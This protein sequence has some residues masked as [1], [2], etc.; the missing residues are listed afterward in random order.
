MI[1]II[2]DT[3]SKDEWNDAATHPMQSWEWGIAR[4]KLGINILRIGEFKKEKLTNVFQIT[5]HTIPFLGRKIGYIP[6]SNLPSKEVLDFLYEYGKKNNIIYFK[7]EPYSPVIP[8][9]AGI[10]SRSRIGVRDDNRLVKSKY[11]LFP[12]WTQIIDL[13]QSEEVLLQ[14]MKSKTR[15]NIRVAQKHNVKVKEETTDEGFNTF[16]NLYFETTKRQNYHGHNQIY[17]RTL[18]EELKSS[19]AHIFIA[20]YNDKPLAAYTLFQFKDTLYYPYGGSSNE[21]KNVMAPNLIMWESI[22]FGKKRGCKGFDMWGSLP[23]DYSENTIWAGFTR[24]KEGY[25]GSF[26]EF[27]GSYDLVIRPLLY[28]GMI[29]AQNLRNTLLSRI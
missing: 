28:H 26:V 17:H 24:F 15:Y 9:K 21:N 16:I 5:L 11:S 10:H 8:A 27:V 6:R 18:F 22:M 19:I 1:K 14:K 12:N 4:E 3:F 29:T 20:Y 23:P 25:G 7:F 2:E 13:T